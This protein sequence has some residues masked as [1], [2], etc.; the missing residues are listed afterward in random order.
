MLF[1]VGRDGIPVMLGMRGRACDLE[2]VEGVLH[3]NRVWVVNYCDYMNNDERVE[4]A[5][6]YWMDDRAAEEPTWAV[7]CVL[8]RAEHH[9]RVGDRV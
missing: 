5:W 6:K 7:P 2:V 1:G 4:G 8:N 9:H 3:Q